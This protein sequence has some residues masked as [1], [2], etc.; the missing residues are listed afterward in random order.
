MINEQLLE[1]QYILLY[2]TIYGEKGNIKI[3]DKNRR[4]IC[5]F[6]QKFKNGKE[7]I[8]YKSFKKI[9]ETDEERV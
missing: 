8:M 5:Q 9:L 1:K 4:K 6:I 7:R 3:V 2:I